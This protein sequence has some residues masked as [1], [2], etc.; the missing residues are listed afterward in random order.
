MKSTQSTLKRPSKTT[1]KAG[2][3]DDPADVSGPA[4]EEKFGLPWSKL[5][6][7]YLSEAHVARSAR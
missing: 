3:A 2:G 4:V 1:K 7:R 5:R 6:K